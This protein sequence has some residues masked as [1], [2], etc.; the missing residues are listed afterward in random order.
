MIFW[1]KKELGEQIERNTQEPLES[2]KK[3]Q[4]YNVKVKKDA[5][6][7]SDLQQ[8]IEELSASMPK[9]TLASDDHEDMLY[10][11]GVKRI[12][13]M[14]D[15]E[16]DYGTVMGMKHSPS[17]EPAYAIVTD[18]TKIYRILNHK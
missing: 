18:L 1:R 7:M 12:K 6:D 5:K 4:E 8:K 2:E 3:T 17:I 14:T 15:Y 11:E 13:V 10:Y 9:D 16:K